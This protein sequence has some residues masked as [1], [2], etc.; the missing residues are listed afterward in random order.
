MACGPIN[1]FT[2]G[3]T[4]A[5]DPRAFAITEFE[6]PDAVLHTLRLLHNVELGW[7]FQQAFIGSIQH[8]CLPYILIMVRIDQRSISGQASPTRKKLCRWPGHTAQS[9][10]PEPKQKS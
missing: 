3:I 4:P 8:P 5:C 1:S 6:E 7:V 10:P 9:D 2:R